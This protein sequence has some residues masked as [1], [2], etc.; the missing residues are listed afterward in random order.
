MRKLRELEYWAMSRG[1]AGERSFEQ[2]CPF[3]RCQQMDDGEGVPSSACCENCRR[4]HIP[5]SDHY[6]GY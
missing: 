2:L 6:I 3:A 4:D 1:M 5:R